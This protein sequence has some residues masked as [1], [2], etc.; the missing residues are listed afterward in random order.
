MGGI[1]HQ[2]DFYGDIIDEY[3]IVDGTSTEDN[4]IGYNYKVIPETV[5]QF[6]GLF[7]KNG[8]KI[9]EGDIVR[10]S[11][12]HE[13]GHVEFSNGFWR[14]FNDDVEEFLSNWAR[15]AY[16]KK[17]GQYIKAEI[18]GNIHDNPELL[19]EADGR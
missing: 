9:F 4:D 8:K 6:T 10:D 3:R 17:L 16:S 5:G 19:G 15:H 11:T 14:V 13:F 2:T 12:G 18:I 1:V 7:D